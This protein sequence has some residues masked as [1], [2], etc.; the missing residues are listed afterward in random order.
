MNRWGLG[1]LLVSIVSLAFNIGCGSMSGS[2]D[3]REWDP[4]LSITGMTSGQ[5][6]LR[7]PRPVDMRPLDIAVESVQVQAADGNLVFDRDQVEQEVR[8]RLSSAVLTFPH[9]GAVR[10]QGNNADL[11]LTARVTKLSWNR[12]DRAV[13]NM[14][15]GDTNFEQGES[16]KH[17]WIECEVHISFAQADGS[18]VASAGG[19]GVKASQSGVRVVSVTT[20]D[21]QSTRSEDVRAEPV[22]E[23]DIPDAIRSALD[24]A[25]ALALPKLESYGTGPQWATVPQ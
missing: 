24:A 21:T 5:V 8:S 6:S 19:L 18:T 7:R 14:F 15:Q 25:I 23:A 1:V 13:S 10:Q 3:P 2:Y 17:S 20:D 11:Y 12:A 9:F 4:A 22:G 16:V